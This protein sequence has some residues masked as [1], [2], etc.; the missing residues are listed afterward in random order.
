MTAIQPGGRY[1]VLDID[2]HSSTIT[3]FVEK[4]KEDGG[5]I[6]GGFMVVEPQAFDY[7]D[8]NEKTSFEREPLENIAKDGGLQAYKHTGFWK[9]MDTQRDKHQLEGMWESHE[10]PWKIW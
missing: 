4:A 2:H 9:C 7:I 6:N 1:G 3:R 10:A 8:D 5:W